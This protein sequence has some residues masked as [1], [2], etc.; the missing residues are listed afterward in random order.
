MSSSLLLAVLIAYFLIL[1][2]ISRSKS[3]DNQIGDFYNAG[4]SA[5]WFVVAFG[6]IGASLSGVTFISVPGWVA[7]R[8]LSYM[9]MVFGYFLGYLIIAHILLPLYYRSNVISIYSILEK[10]LGETGRKTGA[11]FFLIS[12]I[13]GAS[14][15]LY[16][17]IIVLQN[18]VFDSMG[19]PFYITTAIAIAL[20]WTYTYKSG[21]KTVIWTDLLQTASMLIVLV[22]VIVKLSSFL[23]IS[24]FEFPQFIRQSEYGQMFFFENGWSDKMNF[25]KQILAG[26]FITIVMTG[27]DQD[28]MQKNLSCRNLGEAKKN[29][30]SFS[31]VLILINFLFLSLGMLLLAYMQSIGIE[32]PQRMVDGSMKPVTDLIFPTL[33]IEH[34]GPVIGILFFI[35]L[36][37]AAYSS[38]D[39]AL[40]SLTTSFCVDILKMN[41]KEDV[42]EQNYRRKRRLVH[43]GF[44]VVI[45][46]SIIVFYLVNSQ[47][48]IAALFKLAAYTYGP[49]LGMFL[50]VLVF[51]KVKIDHSFIAVVAVISPILS[52]L[53]DKNSST[54]FWGYKFDFEII[55]VNGLICFLG[56]YLVHFWQKKRTSIIE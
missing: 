38:A 23:D 56:L 55:I 40:T 10:G 35:G 48:V 43:I 16:L 33:A 21:I 14:L 26:M 52:F 37:A 24:F 20:V 15:R 28:M 47:A 32:T 50:F 13:L 18:F 42:E 5:P 8:S 2:F 29:M 30:I 9:Q 31:L 12:R 25:F 41:E 11:V 1:F 49:L 54:L 45:Y 17:V 36:I 53:L 44:S 3:K 51:K 7:D 6:M 22:V 19:I 34:L 46:F 39:S 27:L 4:K